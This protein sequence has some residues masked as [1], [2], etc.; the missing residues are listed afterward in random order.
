MKPGSEGSVEEPGK[1]EGSAER[2]HA[3]ARSAARSSLALLIG[4]SVLF[5]SCA[6]LSMGNRVQCLG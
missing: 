4:T 1:E 3:R 5:V 2:K 6:E